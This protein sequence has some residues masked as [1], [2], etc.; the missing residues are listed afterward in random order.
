MT[1][2]TPD[3][4]CIGLNL[5][6]KR[7]YAVAKD[8]DWRELVS[9]EFS[10]RRV[11]QGVGLLG[12]LA[13]VS[14]LLAACGSSS[15]GKTLST[16]ELKISIGAQPNSLDADKVSVG[17]DEYFALN[18]YEYLL[19]YDV[20]GKQIPAVAA[21]M[22]AM[23]SDG[24]VYTFKLR[25]NVKFHDGSTVTADDVKFS[26]ERFVDPKMGNIFAYNLKQ[27]DQVV[28]I[29]PSTVEIHLKQPDVAFLPLNGAARIVPK[30]YIEKVGDDGFGLS[31]I[32]TGPLKFV[33]SQVNKGFVLERF[34]DYWGAKPSFKKYTFSFIP[35]STARVTTLKSGQAELISAIPSQQIAS[36]K[37]ES[38]LV[39]KTA[40]DGDDM[41]IK[42]NLQASQ[43]GKP[44]MDQKVRQALDYAID[45]DVIL[46]KVLLG[47]GQ[48]IS[49][50]QPFDPSYEAGV[51][52]GLKPRAYDPDKAKSLL[53][54]AGYAQGFEISFAGLADGRQP[55]SAELA[56]AVAGYW[57]DIGIKVDLKVLDYSAWIS[58]LKHGTEYGVMYQIWGDSLNGPSQRFTGEYQTGGAYTLIDDPKLDQ[59]LIT[60]SK[61]ISPE[62]ADTNYVTAAKYMNEIAYVLPMYATKGA[63][64]M[65]DTLDWTPWKGISQTRM[66]NAKPAS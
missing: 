50:L 59:L 27:L 19:S 44:W 4:D 62:E 20:N 45:R 23:S 13:G 36:L 64:G 29:D 31:P 49:F 22:P 66:S 42:F 35:D 55:N 34:D 58:S 9:T 52:A 3:R 18:V 5:S 37:K 6:R 21:E 51:K 8:V 46:D 32:G 60:A 38:N 10:R 53:K 26:F 63:Y 1:A 56:Q 7:V 39:I 47:L 54:E 28:I 11:L 14:P 48:K 43:A 30:A 40:V 25:P 41:H 61:S 2:F 15:S 16:D 24:R 65:A 33:S 17:A 57:N 12:A